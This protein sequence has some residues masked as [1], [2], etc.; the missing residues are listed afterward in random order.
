MKYQDYGKPCFIFRDDYEQLEKIP[1]YRGCNSGS[2]G[3]ACIGSCMEV[4]DHLT[5]EEA[6]SKQV[7][8]IVRKF[9]K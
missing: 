9:Y 3:C 4:I 1:V 8:I 5:K 2:F 6:D 7:R